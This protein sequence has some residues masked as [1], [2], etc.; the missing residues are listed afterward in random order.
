MKSTKSKKSKLQY[1]K[2]DISSDSLHPKNAKFRVTMFIDLELLDELRKRAAKRNLPYQTFINQFLRDSIFGK[3][4]E[5][6][7]RKIVR[8]EIERKSA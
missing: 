4:D 7:I 1:G 3:D 5:E 8:D 2:V 6:R